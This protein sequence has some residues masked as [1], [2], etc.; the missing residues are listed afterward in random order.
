MRV[1]KAT[2]A[3]IQTTVNNVGPEQLGR[4]LRSFTS[5]LNSSRFG[6]TSLCPYVQ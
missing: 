5:Q 2:G 3:K 6:H 4:G 1:T